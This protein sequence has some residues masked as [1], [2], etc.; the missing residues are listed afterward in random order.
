MVRGISK[1]LKLDMSQTEVI[2]MEGELPNQKLRQ[3]LRAIRRSQGSIS[4]EKIVVMS[5]IRLNFLLRSQRSALSA[6]ALYTQ[7]IRGN[8]SAAIY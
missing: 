5:N 7:I 3:E 1:L 8:L 2:T 6:S 4:A